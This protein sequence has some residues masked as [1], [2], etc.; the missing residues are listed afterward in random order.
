MREVQRFPGRHERKIVDRHGEYLRCAGKVNG[1]GGDS[2]ALS[3]RIIFVELYDTVGRIGIV[4]F[5]RNEA[6]HFD[7]ATNNSPQK[8]FITIVGSNGDDAGCDGG[9]VRI[10]EDDRTF[11]SCCGIELAGMAEEPVYTC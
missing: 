11:H 1:V 10:I 2:S 7:E 9:T 3:F 4:H 8:R 6:V 5:E